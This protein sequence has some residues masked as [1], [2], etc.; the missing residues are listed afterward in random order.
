MALPA[1]ITT[2]TVTVGVPVTF[3]GAAVRSI[4]SIVPSAFLIHTASGHPLVN[5]IE[6]TSTTDGVAAQFTL[7]H[8]DQDGF[9]D[10]SGN[11]YK[12]WYYTAT[13]QYQNDRVTKPAITKV[14]QLAA[15]Q[16]LVDLDLLPGGSPAMPYTAPIAGVTSVNGQT[17]SVLVEGVTDSAVEALVSDPASATAVSLSAT[18]GPDA[19]GIKNKFRRIGSVADKWAPRRVRQKV[20]PMAVPPTFGAGTTNGGSAANTSLTNSTLIKYDD[21][22]L[23]YTGGIMVPFSGNPAWYGLPGAA[24]GAAP[25]TLSVRFG[26][27]GQ[28]FEW[29]TNGTGTLYRVWVN[30]VPATANWVT[31]PLDGLDHLMT[32]DLGSRDVWDI[33]IDMFNSYFGGV[34][35]LPTDL[36]YKPSPACPLRVHIVGDSM[37]DGQSYSGGAA[38]YTPGYPF[39]LGELL[40]I[41]DV[42]GRGRGGTGFLTANSFRSRLATDVIPYAPDVV[43]IP[44]SVNDS[45]TT[46]VAGSIQA[47][48]V[49]IHNQLKAALPNTVIIWATTIHMGG[50]NTNIDQIN[51]E[52]AAAATQLGDPFLDLRPLNTG[53]GKVGT[54]TGDGS[55]DYNRSADGVHPEWPMGFDHLAVRMANGLAPIL[56]ASN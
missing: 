48:A 11:A 43:I 28:K 9:Q 6:E 7:P 29:R 34:R 22:R 42:W 38:T 39:R 27:E 46:P 2:A 56:S 31:L 5:L 47:E 25:R 35:I 40:Q 18:Y 53:T 45:N 54:P 3:S 10:E 20:A 52:L 19:A 37:T 24:T 41:E 30:G 50:G 15:G 21:A 12:N 17:G 16:T 44:G 51:N 23:T 14:F 8:T 32:V 55:A 13:I 49:L 4:V 1:G 36:L 33:R 26:F